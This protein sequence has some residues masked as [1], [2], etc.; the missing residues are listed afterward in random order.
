MRQ[1]GAGV[2]TGVEFGI[3]TFGANAF[4]WM[5]GDRVIGRVTGSETIG[6]IWVTIALEART[7]VVDRREALL[8]LLLLLV[9]RVS[10]VEARVDGWAG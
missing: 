10:T 2:I 5:I 1:R 9:L 3:G 4:G 8:L 6:I 7:I